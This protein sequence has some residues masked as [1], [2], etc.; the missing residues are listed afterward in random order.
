MTNAE[1]INLALA[2]G[3]LAIMAGM[4]VMAILNMTQS[5]SL[6]DLPAEAIKKAVDG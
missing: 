3:V 6:D 4:I 5:G 1:R 2:V